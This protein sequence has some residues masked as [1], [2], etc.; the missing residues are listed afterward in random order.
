[1]H[2]FFFDAVVLLSS[3]LITLT[4]FLTFFFLHLIV[5]LFANDC[6][7]VE[8]DP[9]VVVIFSVVQVYI[10]FKLLASFLSELLDIA[11]IAL[12]AATEGS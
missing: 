11:T 10:H 8:E 3:H 1:M 2:F 4:S 9:H 12:A 6:V 5:S 7:V